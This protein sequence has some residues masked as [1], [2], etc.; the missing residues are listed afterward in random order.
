[1]TKVT[2]VNRFT[3]TFLALVVIA[4]LSGGLAYQT[5]MVFV[6]GGGNL[7]NAFG[8]I[9]SASVFSFSMLVLAR[10]MRLTAVRRDDHG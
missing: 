7:S 5:A 3:L 4:T 2:S 1:M 9:I 10:I 6:A 8:F